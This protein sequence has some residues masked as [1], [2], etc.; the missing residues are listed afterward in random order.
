M[1][2]E[3]EVTEFVESE[4]PETV[5]E[6]SE[7]VVTETDI[8]EFTE[9]VTTVTTINYMSEISLNTARTANCVSYLAGFSV[10]ASAIFI[11]TVIIKVFFGGKT[12]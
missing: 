1:D 8:S 9:T 5:F 2:T 3:I 4:V 12:F 7:T 10:I 11:S 6:T